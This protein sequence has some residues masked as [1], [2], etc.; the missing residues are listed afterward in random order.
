VL[1]TCSLLRLVQQRARPA[2]WQVL[3]LQGPVPQGP[4]LQPVPLG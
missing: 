1:T 3:V 2:Y 4:V